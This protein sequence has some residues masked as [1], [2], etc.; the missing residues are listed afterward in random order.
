MQSNLVLAETGSL[1]LLTIANSLRYRD[2]F[3]MLCEH[4]RG[5]IEQ[6]LCRVDKSNL[7]W[8]LLLVRSAWSPAAVPRLF[9]DD[10]L[11][12]CR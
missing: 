12:E 2:L 3:E 7:S 1:S 9:A 8:Y 4:P 5:K 6:W 10:L 11:Q